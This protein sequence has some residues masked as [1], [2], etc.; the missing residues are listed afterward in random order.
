MLAQAARWVGS[1]RTPPHF[2]RGC[3]GHF[4]HSAQGA[5]CYRYDELLASLSDCAASPLLVACG[6]G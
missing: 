5:C 1:I 6:A 4:A 2:F 3:F